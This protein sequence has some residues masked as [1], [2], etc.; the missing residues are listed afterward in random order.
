MFLI[1]F[2]TSP[3]GRDVLFGGS[4][5]GGLG[6]AMRFSPR[7]TYT[8][9]YTPHHLPPSGCHLLSAGPS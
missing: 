7:G 5:E 9:T 8:Y 2:V 4:L 1:V 3:R 6:G